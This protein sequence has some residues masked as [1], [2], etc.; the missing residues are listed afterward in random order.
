MRSLI[1][2]A[3]QIEGNVV[4]GYDAGE[5]FCDEDWQ[6]LVQAIIYE[7]WNGIMGYLLV[8]STSH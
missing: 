5:L 1:V 8:L 2:T 3:S 4:G 6:Y 7:R